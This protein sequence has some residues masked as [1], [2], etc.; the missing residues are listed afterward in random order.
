MF[1]G[2][3]DDDT[4]VDIFAWN[5]DRDFLKEHPQTGFFIYYITTMC[6]LAAACLTV[7]PQTHLS[8]SCAVATP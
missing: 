7:C 4:K 5:R 3:P 8:L 6:A 2:Y 1:K